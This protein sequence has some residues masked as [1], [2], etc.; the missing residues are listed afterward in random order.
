MITFLLILVTYYFVGMCVSAWMTKAQIIRPGWIKTDNG[1]WVNCSDGEQEAFAYLLVPIGWPLLI[2][3]KIG[4]LLVKI[5][6][7]IHTILVHAS[8]VLN[9]RITKENG[10][11]VIRFHVPKRSEL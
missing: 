10:D 8:N 1:N 3:F 2:I 6:V 5:H 4:C 9:M 7:I 11:T